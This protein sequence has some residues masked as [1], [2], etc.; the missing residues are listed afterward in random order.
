MESTK[1]FHE[2]ERTPFWAEQL[3][4]P[5]FMNLKRDHETEVCIVGAGIAGLTTAY[6]LLQEGKKVCVLEA[7]EIGSGQ[8]GKSTAHFTTAI[9]DR[10]FIIEKILGAETAKKVARSH[11]SALRLVQEIVRKEKIDCDLEEVDGYL[12]TSNHLSDSLENEL[13]AVNR[14]GIEDAYLIE[15]APLPF[16]SGP[17]IR[18]PKQLQLH[19]LKYLKGLAEAIQAKGGSIFTH[20]HVSEVHGGNKANVVTSEGYRVNCDSIVVATNTPINN[21]FAVHNKQTA[22]RTY[23][24]GAKIPAGSVTKALYWDLLDSYHYIRIQKIENDLENV[25]LLVGGE[26]HRTGQDANPEQNYINLE[27]WVRDR[28]TMVKEFTHRWSGQII[29]PFDGLAYLGH[30]PMDRENVYIIT[31]DSGNGMTHA[32]IGAMIITDQITLRKNPW[33]EIYSPSRFT[34]KAFRDYIKENLD[35]VSGYS[36]WMKEQTEE[37]Y[38]SIPAGEGAVFRRGMKMIAAY[39]D[40][41]QHIELRSAVCPHLG[42]IVKWNSSEKSWDCPCHGSRFDCHGKLLDGPANKDLKPIKETISRF[43]FLKPFLKIKPKRSSEANP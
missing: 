4:M 10:Y 17:A 18:F 33:E 37:D 26:G 11:R 36:D 43:Q 42:G 24:V 21:I 40:M 25:M 39:K 2:N 20:T 9:D 3:E 29:E 27:S 1:I 5:K 7:F 38:D 14:A 31:G 6:L 19:P 28:F 35:A 8:S 12:I 13:K 16:H 23:V 34:V 30:N 41:N 15:N 32:T 22:F